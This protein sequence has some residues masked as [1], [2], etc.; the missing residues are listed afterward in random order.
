[1]L[2][3]NT[4]WSTGANPS[5]VASLSAQAG[6]FAFP[7]GSADSALVANLTPGTYTVQ[8]SGTGSS[9]GVGLVEVYETSDSDPSQLT[10]ISTRG[11]V[12]TGGNIMIAGFVVG[13]SQPAKVLVRGVGPGLAAFGVSGVLA[14]PTIVVFDQAGNQV[15]SNTGWQTAADPTQASTIAS[16]VGAFALSTAS[17][18]SALVL[19]LQPGVY[20]VQVTGSDGGTGVALAEVYQVLQ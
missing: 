7:S 20:S 13:G 2:A 12:G 19:T 16:Q 1:V 4:G 11:F 18:D 17:A 5:L 15:G 10:N 3:T 9:T 6:A 8:L 14:K